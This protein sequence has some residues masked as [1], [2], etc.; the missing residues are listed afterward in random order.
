[1]AQVDAGIRPRWFRRL[2]LDEQ[3]LSS[4]GGSAH[5][6]EPALQPGAFG[7]ALNLSSPPAIGGSTPAAGAFTNLTGNGIVHLTDNAAALLALQNG[8]WNISAQTTT[9][10]LTGFNVNGVFSP[11]AYG[12]SGSTATSVI[13]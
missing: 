8:N 7:S 13:R 10:A 4:A 3:C 2:D 9:G 1:L 11:D 5:A 12:A 6:F